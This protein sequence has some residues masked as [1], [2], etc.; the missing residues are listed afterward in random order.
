VKSRSVAIIAL[1]AV[2]ASGCGVGVHFADYRHTATLADAHVTGD[3]TSLRLEADDGHVVVT[4]GGSAGVT[5]HRVVHYQS[6]T[7]HPEQHLVDGTLTFDRG[8]SRCRVDYDLTVPASVRVQARTDSGRIDV[9]GVASA[10]AGS[11]SGSVV[12]R[13]VTGAVSA[14]SDSGRITLQ[15]V[16]GT[17]AASTDSGAI[18]GTELRSP[19][20]TVSSDSGGL[21]LAFTQ[22][23]A[24]VRATTDSGSVRLALPG[25]PY[26]VDLQTDSGGKHVGV[27]TASTASAKLYLRSDSGGVHVD[28]A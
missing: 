23:P 14:R 24:S 26:D 22:A 19:T 27:P 11:D 21:R 9:S 7:P 20:S 1:T 10:D 17:L 5:V 16:G 6:G 15:D 2:T 8:C 18:R 3:V 25:G 4:R 12:V 13:H 28:P